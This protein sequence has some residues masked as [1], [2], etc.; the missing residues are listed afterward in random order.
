MRVPPVSGQWPKWTKGRDKE[1]ER[2]AEIIEQATAEE[3]ELDRDEVTAL[4]L[5]FI[6]R[7]VER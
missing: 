1:D 7:A 4:V 5:D 3:K 6:K 2:L